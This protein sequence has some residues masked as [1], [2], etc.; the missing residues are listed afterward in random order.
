MKTL[1]DANSV[2]ITKALNRQKYDLTTAKDALTKANETSMAL[3]K[4][5]GNEYA[6]RRL[7]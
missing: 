1:L 7:H 3:D 6:L 2:D 5:K 4:D